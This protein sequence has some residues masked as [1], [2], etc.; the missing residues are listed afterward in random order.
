MN[1]N[2]I[3]KL[4]ECLDA[5]RVLTGDALQERYTHIWKMDQGLVAQ[6]YVLPK[7]TAEVSDILQLCHSHNQPVQIFGGL[8]NLVGGT[9]THPDDIVISMEKMNFIEEINIHDRTMRVQ[10]GVV[11]QNIQQLA[12]DHALLFPLNFGAKGSAQI[13]GIISS[14]AGGLRVFRYGMTRNLVLGLEVVLA[15]G[16]IINCLKSLIKDNSGYDLKHIFIGSEGTLGIVTRAVLRLQ[17]AP[18]SRVS[19]MVALQDYDNVVGL[20]KHLDRGMAGLLSG[21]ELMWNNF[22]TMATSAPSQSKPPLEQSYKY[23][24]LC[25]VM[26]SDQVA[27]TNKLY[28]LIEEALDRRLV[29]DAVFAENSSDLEWFWTIREDVHACVSQLSFDQHFDISLPTAK[30]GQ[31]LD[32]VGKNLKATTGVVNFV[33]FGHIADGNVHIV[34]GKSND[35]KELTHTINTIVYEP[36]KEIGGSI[37]AEHGIGEHK[38]AYLSYSRSEAE[39]NLMKTLKHALDPRSILNRGKIVD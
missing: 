16:T 20:L 21:F 35:S 8:T 38:K 22:Y 3:D 7:T 18:K 12:S 13:G 2:L 27:D 30:I 26:G 14:N 28:T 24:V 10:G 11:L 1:E 19:A 34:V 5:N 36:L 9:E 39:L 17:E 32:D 31:T 33:T 4:V 37:S 15:D 6:A 25:E 29:E 23:Y